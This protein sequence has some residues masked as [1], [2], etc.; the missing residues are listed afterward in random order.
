MCAFADICV[1]VH[2]RLTDLSVSHA[3]EPFIHQLVSFGVSGLTLHN[4]TLC[5]LVR[6]RDCRNLKHR[7]R[8]REIMMTV[9]TEMLIFLRVCER[10]WRLVPEVRITLD[11]N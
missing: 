8:E 10:V 1:R 2:L 11:R 5:R 6:Q 3:D 9:M 4:V 7:E